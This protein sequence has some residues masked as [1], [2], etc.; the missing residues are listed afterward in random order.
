MHEFF[1]AESHESVGLAWIQG[2]C[3][4]VRNGHKH[5]PHIDGTRACP[6]YP[7][8]AMFSFDRSSPVVDPPQYNMWKER[9]DVPDPLAD[10]DDTIRRSLP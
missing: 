7:S 4:N 1:I 3:N 9:I 6:G 5:E 2:N 8:Q 10:I